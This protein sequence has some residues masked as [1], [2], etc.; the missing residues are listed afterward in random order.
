MTYF[1]GPFSLHEL[2]SFE[3][4]KLL[5]IRAYALASGF[6]SDLEDAL[7]LDSGRL[8]VHTELPQA[9]LH[10][11]G[12]TR[13]DGDLAVNQGGVSVGGYEALVPTAA[14]VGADLQAALDARYVKGETIHPSSTVADAAFSNVRV[15]HHTWLNNSNGYIGNRAGGRTVF[16]S[17]GQG[18]NVA[19][20][21]SN[22]PTYG[23][24]C[25]P[26][27]EVGLRGYYGVRMGVG[28]MTNLTLASPNGFVGVPKTT[29]AFPLDVAGNCCV[30][31]TMTLS[32]STGALLLGTSNGRL[33]V[34]TS[35]PQ[36]AVDVIGSVKASGD[37]YATGVLATASNVICTSPGQ[38]LTKDLIYSGEVRCS[39]F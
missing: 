1:V 26:T 38:V 18:S 25:A 37:V 11:T 6:T 12:E 36:H 24:G 9:P 16:L 19:W 8:G 28:T 2:R 7:T 35:V 21:A 13:L 30:R 17:L 32:N 10:V 5:S 29:P 14:L 20:A 31:G 27:G 3:K 33:G 4:A 22:F 15:H 39:V 23:I 34:G